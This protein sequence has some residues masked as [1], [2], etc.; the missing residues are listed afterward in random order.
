MPSVSISRTHGDGSPSVP[1]AAAR[2]VLIYDRDAVSA[3]AQLVG[4]F[5]VSADPDTFAC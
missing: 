1:S 2:M 4:V 5:T 3:G